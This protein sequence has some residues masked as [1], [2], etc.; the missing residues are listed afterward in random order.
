VT[1]KRL[2]IEIE[3]SLMHATLTKTILTQCFIII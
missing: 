3:A 2:K 1:Q